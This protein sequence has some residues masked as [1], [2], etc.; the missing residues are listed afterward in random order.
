MKYSFLLALRYI[1]FHKLKTF[2]L[3]LCITLTL[4]LPFTITQMVNSYH[5]RMMLRAQSTPLIAGSTG[6]RLDLVLHALYFKEKV[7]GTLTM[8]SVE[9]IRQS[10][11]ARPIPLLIDG[12]AGG[13]P[14]VGTNPD[15]FQFRK[16]QFAG[17]QPIKRLGDCV[18]GADVAEALNLSPGEQLLSDP[19]NVF[20]IAGA[21]PL[22]MNI[23]GVLR[24]TGSAD[25]KAVFTDLKTT[26]LI[27]GLVHGHKDLTQAADSSLIL[28]VDGNTIIANAAVNQYTE[29]TDENITSFHFHGLENEFPV[30]AVI[31]LPR[32]KKSE[33]LLRGRYLSESSKEQVI[34][35]AQVI[36][37]LM[38][39]VF[40]IKTFF[41]ANMIIIGISTFLL[42]LL[43]I[44]LSLR[45]RQHEME[46]M[47]KIGC[48]RWTTAGLQLSE[49]SIILAIS[50]TCSAI[51]GLL[52]IQLG[53][54][55]LWDLLLRI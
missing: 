41:D 19:E 51:L 29:I 13:Y 44:V 14:I 34:I 3:V 47:F 25:D 24:R 30:S 8:K 52:T 39:I 46:I 35:P 49:L 23:R 28:G 22:L 45:L 43:V 11:Y 5:T 17:G 31:A 48:S 42:L 16:L 20:D 32:D 7:S 4:Y 15:Y 9:R 36:T 54:Y 40:K 37:E 33:T 1:S 12:T 6:S 53:D 2:I 26:W 55:I 50:I 18:L 21:Y 38:G 27:C 10:G